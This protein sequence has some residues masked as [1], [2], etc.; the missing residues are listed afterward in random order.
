MID[1]LR[2]VLGHTYWRARGA[3]GKR[4]LQLECRHRNWRKASVPI[5][6]RARCNDCNPGLPL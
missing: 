3:G 4:C 1:P 6:K 5:P 2:K